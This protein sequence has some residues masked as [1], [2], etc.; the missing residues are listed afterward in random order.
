MPKHYTKKPVISRR[1]FGYTDHYGNVFSL[2]RMVN[3]NYCITEDTFGIC[4]EYI[5]LSDAIEEMRRGII[6]S[7]D[8]IHREGERE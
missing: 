4:A 8:Y 5:Y 2:R 1:L 7:L 3:G 6:E